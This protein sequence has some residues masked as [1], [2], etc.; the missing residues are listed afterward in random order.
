MS[1][2]SIADLVERALRDL[3]EELL[4]PREGEC[5][6][7]YVARNLD[8]H[9]CDHSHRHALRYRD[10]TAPQATALV[11]RLRSMEACCDCEIF[12]NAYQLRPPPREEVLRD[13]LRDEDDTD[14]FDASP[15]CA[16]VP[17]GSVEPCSNWVGIRGY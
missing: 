9:S 4:W 16:G 17:R 5:L 3:A 15:E 6:C 2:P 10:T 7:C 14:D 12:L 1:I 13:I 8:D 11:A